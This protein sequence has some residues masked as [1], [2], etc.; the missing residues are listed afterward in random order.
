MLAGFPTRWLML[1]VCLAYCGVVRA[2]EPLAVDD[3]MWKDPPYTS[4]VQRYDFPP[5]ITSLWKKALERPDSELRRSAADTVVIAQRKGVPGLEELTNNLLEILKATDQQ[6]SVRRAAAHA[7]VLMDASAH[8][9]LLAQ[10]AEQDGLDVAQFVEP[11][12]AKWKYAPIEKVWLQRLEDPVVRPMWL[13]L[14]IRC[15]AERKESAA[16]QPLLKLV[17][18]RRAVSTIRLAAAQSLAA[19]CTD[20]LVADAKQHTADPV[21]ENSL[22]R[23]LGTTLISRH[24]DPDA[25]SLL[26]QMAVDKEP[27]V[28]AIALRQL[29][30]IDP[31][32]VYD[33][34]P[35]A[36]KSTDVNVRRQGVEAFVVKADEASV[37]QLASLLN[38]LNPSL[39]ARVAESL[40]T[41]AAKPELR[42]V[43]IAETER[44]LTTEGWRG[45]E[46]AILLAV[47]LERKNNA[48]RML[49][50]LKHPR[51][52]VAVSAAWALRRF[53][54]PETLAKMLEH[55]QYQY[56]R[57]TKRQILGH[58]SPLIDGQ[59]S[60][61][62]QAFGQLRYKEAEPLMRKFVPKNFSLG[63]QARSAA[64]WALGY[65]HE[66][67]APEDL[68]NQLVDRLSDIASMMPEVTPVRA[69]CGVSLGRMKAKTKIDVVRQ[70]ADGD[71]VGSLVGQ[72]C[73]WALEQMT[74][75]KRPPIPEL[76]QRILGW[77]LQ[78]LE[79]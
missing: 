73:W 19:I 63:M 35:Q 39:R 28:A 59:H 46:K 20:G 31:A 27:P 54:L 75:E 17:H 33:L 62:F 79:K 4:P 77:F 7:L 69:A 6:S 15:L 45:L 72:S 52:E 23:L 26:K 32:L 70:F 74:D 9:Q 37:R 22:E 57:I 41:L 44:T 60:Q 55:A 25:I 11:A 2:D 53:Q 50:L 36:I 65:L 1:V 13:L 67:N 29:F 71:G 5:N 68:A 61:L 30:A 38:D 16:R 42:P 21:L 76:R 24:S 58:E 3:I 49:E 40:L 64:I 18:D 14:A 8:A 56:D 48:D 12:L 10:A 47:R 78:P 43:V 34:A 51:D 66:N